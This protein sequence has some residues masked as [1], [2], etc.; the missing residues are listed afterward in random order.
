MSSAIPATTSPS[1]SDPHRHLPVVEED[2]TLTRPSSSRTMPAW[3]GSRP[4]TSKSSSATH[5]GRL[6]QSSANDGNAN[7]AYPTLDFRDSRHV[8]REANSD[9]RTAVRPPTSR[10]RD[11]MGVAANRDRGVIAFVCGAGSTPTRPTGCA[12]RWPDE[13]SDI[14]VFNLR[15]NRR[16]EEPK[17]ARSGRRLR[18][19]SRGLYCDGRHS[20]AGAAQKRSQQLSTTVIGRLPDRARKKVREVR[21]KC[22]RRMDPSPISQQGR[23]LAQPASRRLRHF[24]PIGGTSPRTF[25]LRPSCPEA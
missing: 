4:S 16:Q 10:A 3:S 14:Y 20:G 25:D 18:A 11:Q 2:D 15:G 19:Q 23:R 22:C 5:R 6:G 7:E 21:H 24:L 1:W 8:R 9:Q 12:L 17:V 13:F